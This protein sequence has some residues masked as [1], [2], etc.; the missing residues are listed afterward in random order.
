ML[1]WSHIPKD[2]SS[3]GMLPLASYSSQKNMMSFYMHLKSVPMELNIFLQVIKVICYSVIWIKEHQ[4]KCSKGNWGHM[5]IKFSVLNGANMIK[6]YFSVGVGIKLC[7]FGILGLKLLL[8]RF[9]EATSVANLLT[10][11]RISYW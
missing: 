4:F 3:I 5:A 9:M 11:L 8:T 2:H 6:M 7:S 10:V 1:S